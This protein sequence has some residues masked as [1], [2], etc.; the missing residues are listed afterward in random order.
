V[1]IFWVPGVEEVFAGLCRGVQW[2]LSFGDEGAKK[3]FGA[4]VEDQIPVEVDG[5]RGFA[6]L[7]VILILKIFPTVI[8]ASSAMSVLYH[9]GWLQRLVRGMAWLVRKTIQVSGAEALSASANV[10]LGMT[11]APLMIRPYLGAMTAS[12]L[13]AVMV[14][15]F[16]TISG[17]MMAVYSSLFKADFSYLLAA[18]LLNV[19]AALYLTK[20]FLPETEPRKFLESTHLEVKRTTV[21]VVDAAAGGALTGLQLALNIGAV[22]LAF[23]AGLAFIDGILAYVGSFFIR[24]GTALSLGRIFSWIFFPMAWLLGVPLDECWAVG[25]LLGTKIALNEYFA[26]EDLSDLQLSQRTRGIAIFALCGFANFGSI[27]IQLGGL[28]ALIPERRS[29]LARM[30]VPAMLLGALANCITAAIAGMVLDFK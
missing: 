4:L 22:L 9:L 8:F 17:S 25:R 24:D 29:E 26:Y 19:P 6:A 28:G 14:G 10:F 11:E 21:N 16:A 27:A 20:I 13:K 18:S 30:G 7:G 5:A 23:A 3:I 15:G 1:L 12:E 2:F